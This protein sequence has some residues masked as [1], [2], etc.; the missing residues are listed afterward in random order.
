M[1]TTIAMLDRIA[2]SP[3]MLRIQCVQVSYPSCRHAEVGKQ[4]VSTLLLYTVHEPSV[5]CRG[6]HSLEPCA[7]PLLS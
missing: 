3:V 1:E 5:H 4:V 7:L 2:A 6:S